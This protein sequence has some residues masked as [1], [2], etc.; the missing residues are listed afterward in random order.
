[1]FAV[2]SDL[3]LS[4]VLLISGSSSSGGEEETNE[5]HARGEV[6]SDQAAA[7]GIC[8]GL[9]LIMKNIDNSS[10]QLTNTRFGNLALTCYYVVLTLY[11]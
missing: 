10:C 2:Q 6:A 1:M 8:A 5:Q 9:L 4:R 7:T 3:Y 11:V